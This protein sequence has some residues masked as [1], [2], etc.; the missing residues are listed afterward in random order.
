MRQLCF[1]DPTNF[2]CVVICNI[3]SVDLLAIHYSD[4]S[5]NDFLLCVGVCD[6]TGRNG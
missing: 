5:F 6:F 3:F 2:M 4:F 1:T